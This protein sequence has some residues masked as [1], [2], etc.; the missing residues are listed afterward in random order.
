MWKQHISL[1]WADNF[2]PYKISI[3][4]IVNCLQKQTW[5]YRD[6][7]ASRTGITTIDFIGTSHYQY[8]IFHIFHS[9]L[10]NIHTIASQQFHV[11]TW[12]LIPTYKGLVEHWVNKNW[13][14]SNYQERWVRKTRIA[15]PGH[16]ESS[17]YGV[18]LVL[19]FMGK[20]AYVME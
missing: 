9:E 18:N 13:T 10:I 20:C 8:Q 11:P 5:P 14:L 6:L 4:D 17:V 2:I 7:D 15:F 16:M 3:R 1:L 19:L 12:I